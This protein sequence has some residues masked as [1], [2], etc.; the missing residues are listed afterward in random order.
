MSWIEFHARNVF[1]TWDDS[2][3]RRP[4]KFPL[5]WESSIKMNRLR[6]CL[7]WWKCTLFNIQFTK[8]VKKKPNQIFTRTEM[9]NVLHCAAINFYLLFN[10]V[11]R[12]RNSPFLWIFFLYFFFPSFLYGLAPDQLVCNNWLAWNFNSLIQIKFE[13]FMF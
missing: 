3:F 9:A 8:S 1:I 7:L 10:H 13:E 12:S 2:T 11:R 5:L 4:P 6:N